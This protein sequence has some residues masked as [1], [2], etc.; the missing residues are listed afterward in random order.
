MTTL[1]L[2]LTSPKISTDVRKH[3]HACV[4]DREPE[5]AVKRRQTQHLLHSKERS[6]RESLFIEPH[7]YHSVED[8]LHG[9]EDVRGMHPVLSEGEED[10][11]LLLELGHE[12]GPIV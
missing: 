1:V 5:V 7:F 12:L 8:L 6:D 9:S 3:L 2:S 10:R 11:V 4:R